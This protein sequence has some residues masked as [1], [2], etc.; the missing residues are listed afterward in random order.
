[1]NKPLRESFA[2]TLSAWADAHP[3]PDK[4]VLSLGTGYLSPRQLASAVKRDTPEGQ[5]FCRMV[6]HAAN[7]TGETPS[8][9][10]KHFQAPKP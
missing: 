9:F 3:A 7:T 10:F 2:K 5:L 4:P 8:Q 1:M 6:E